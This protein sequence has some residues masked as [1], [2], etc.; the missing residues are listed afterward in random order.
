MVELYR[1]GNLQSHRLSSSGEA[2]AERPLTET[3]TWLTELWQ[4]VLK[5][6]SPSLHDNFFELGGDLLA[7][8]ELIFAM[9]ERFSCDLPLEAFFERPTIATMDALLTQHAKP[10]PVLSAA[11]LPEGRAEQTFIGCKVSA[12][13]G[14]ASGY[15]ATA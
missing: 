7:S 14:E 11:P 4:R 8:A 9:K 13:V 3:Q 12:G 2:G 5:L 6:K 10:S 1:S 15:L